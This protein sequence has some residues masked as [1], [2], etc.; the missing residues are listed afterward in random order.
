MV[1]IGLFQFPYITKDGGKTWTNS[2]GAQQAIT[3]YAWE[4]NGANWHQW[5]NDRVD[6]NYWYFYWYSGFFVSSDG[7]YNWKSGGYVGWENGCQP[8]V[9]TDFAKAGHVCVAL[10]E[11]GLRCS[12][13]YGQNFTTIEQVNVSRLVGFGRSK[14]DIK[15]SVMYYFGISQKDRDNGIITQAPYQIDP[16]TGDHIR[17]DTNSTYMLG[18][19][20]Q[21]M[22]GDRQTYGRVYIG[23]EGRGVYFSTLVE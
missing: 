22:R 12:T 17:M 9:K 6:G 4:W 21:L 2:T 5:A 1:W 20:P 18:K 23:S 10:G 8:L 7:G 19:G 14:S 11:N 13:D 15:Q 3:G 16:D